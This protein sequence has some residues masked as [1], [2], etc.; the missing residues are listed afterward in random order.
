M[1]QYITYYNWE[2]KEMGHWLKS[3]HPKSPGDLFPIAR[4]PPPLRFYTPLWDPPPSLT[5]ASLM[6]PLT[7]RC[8]TYSKMS[9]DAEFYTHRHHRVLTE[10][11]AKE[12]PAGRQDPWWSWGTEGVSETMSFFFGPAPP[13][14]IR[15]KPGWLWKTVYLPS[16]PG[17]WADW[18]SSCDLGDR[19]HKIHA[20]RLGRLTSVGLSRGVSQLLQNGQHHKHK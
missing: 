14:T 15:Q 5:D 18:S 2:E 16:P 3:P 1:F 20:P 11:A 8:L 4:A 7:H 9:E 6:S 17:S 10:P 19:R 13:S 12:R